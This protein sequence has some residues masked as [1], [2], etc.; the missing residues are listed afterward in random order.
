MSKKS[1]QER[2]ETSLIAHRTVR[3]HPKIVKKD[4]ALAQYKTAMPLHEMC[5][6]G[7]INSFVPSKVSAATN[8]QK[9]AIPDGPHKAIHIPVTQSK[10]GMRPHSFLTNN[11][12]HPQ[13]DT[14]TTIVNQ[15]A[16][17]IN[18][19]EIQKKTLSIKI[20][21]DISPKQTSVKLTQFKSLS[22]RH[23]NMDP[24]SAEQQLNA[25]ALQPGSSIMIPNHEPAKY[26]L[27]RNGIVRAYAANTNQGLVR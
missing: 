11:K 4:P 8:G 17:A 21:S 6:L 23:G 7:A 22:T 19:T 15:S 5:H 24:I 3:D 20:P 1:D 25:P 26:S 12:G 16:A 14:S 27:K 13:T 9:Y 10:P 18:P 2:T